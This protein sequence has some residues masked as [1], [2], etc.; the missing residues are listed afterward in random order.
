MPAFIFCL[1]GLPVRFGWQSEKKSSACRPGIISIPVQR[2]GTLYSAFGVTARIIFPKIVSKN[3]NL[4]FKKMITK[5]TKTYFPTNLLQAPINKKGSFPG[6]LFYHTR[7][8]STLSKQHRHGPGS[9]RLTT[10]RRCEIT[11][12]SIFTGITRSIFIP[13]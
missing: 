8:R 5:P 6:C 10:L 4:R 1:S 3:C 7:H 9:F 11:L 13:V 2:N 12:N